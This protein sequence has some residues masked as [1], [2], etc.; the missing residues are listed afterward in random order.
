MLTNG[1]P[2]KISY[3]APLVRLMDKAT[4]TDHSG[5]VLTGA[6]S[7]AGSAQY[8]SAN[9][10]AFERN[11]KRCA[12]FILSG[13]ALVIST[14]LF[15]LCAIAIRCE[16]GGPVIF[17]QERIGRHGR[18]FTIYKFRTMRPDAERSGIR[19]CPG[20]DDPRI[21][22]TGR[23]LRARHLDEL[24][25]L[26]NILRG[27]MSLVGPRPERQYYIDRIL[28]R[29][30][31]YASLYQ[32]RPGATS[33]ATLHNGYTGTME[34]MLRR[35]DLDLLYLRHGSLWLDFRILSE[36]LARLLSGR[37]F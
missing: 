35:L 11:A 14:P 27:D 17:R 3:R 15:A 20:S 2:C 36:T 9:L 23:F 30:P 26:Y 12:D 4:L 6:D 13:L 31:R 16:D 32:L 10:S 19:L 34:K 7:Y 28:E 33:Y 29:D 1:C 21:T 8:I 5:I 18:P 37:K 22:R 24:P 25:Q